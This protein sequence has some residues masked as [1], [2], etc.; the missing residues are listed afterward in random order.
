VP[1]VKAGWKTVPFAALLGNLQDSIEDFEV[2]KFH[3]AALNRQA[4]LD[5]FVLSSRDF[6]V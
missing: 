3:V 5:L 1:F 4:I 6:H 2:L